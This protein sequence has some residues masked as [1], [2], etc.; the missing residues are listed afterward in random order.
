MPLQFG[1]DE[2]GYG[3]NLGPL[4]QSAVGI[5]D[6][7]DPWQVHSDIVRRAAGPTD[8]RLIVDDSKAVNVG[9]DGLAKLESGVF[10]AF[11]RFAT[12]GEL[13]ARC[14]IATSAID[15][16]GEP[17]YRAERPLPVFA[18]AE[19]IAAARFPNLEVRLPQI[20]ITPAPRFNAILN[21]HGTKAAVTGRGLIELI[22]SLP[23]GDWHATID[24]QGGRNY[25]APMLQ[26]ALPDHWIV[27]G[28]EGAELSEYRIEGRDVRFRFLPRAESQSFAVALAS[29]LSKYLREVL[30]VQFNEYWI[31]KVPGLKPT[32]GYPMDAKRYYESI[33]HLVQDADTV[34]RRK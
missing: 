20:A 31:A 17:W 3:P 25:Y 4:V 29:M 12:L 32:A 24:K 21:V 11:G 33:R 26:E 16:E 34:W 6:E 5:A 10:A 15:L 2:A 23:A 8:G 18:S 13:I 22:R 30:M 9:P 19:R 14:G 1:I 28:C 7:G 27:T